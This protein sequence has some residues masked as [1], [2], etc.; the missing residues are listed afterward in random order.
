MNWK[1]I[2]RV[3]VAH[4]PLC[5]NR[6]RDGEI[7]ATLPPIRLLASKRVSLYALRSWCRIAG[8]TDRS[9]HQDLYPRRARRDLLE[10]AGRTG[11][12]ADQ[13]F[14]DK[15]VSCANPAAL[16]LRH[17]ARP[18]SLLTAG[19]GLGLILGDQFDLEELRPK[20]GGDKEAPSVSVVGNPVE[21]SLLEV[22]IARV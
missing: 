5:Q 3:S 8:R 18:T 15:P 6:L 16:S 10:R 4:L 14:P 7:G 19:A 22:A 1:G 13:I 21:H 2:P 17:I 20:L 11:E 12:P 9:P